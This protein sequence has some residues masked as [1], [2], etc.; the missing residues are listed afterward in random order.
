MWRYI[1]LSLLPLHVW[2]DLVLAAIPWRAP[3]SLESL[4]APLI[5]II[6]KATGQKVSFMVSENYTQL[7]NQVE[8]AKADIAIFGANSYIEAKERIPNLIYLATC[9]I[10]N[11]HYKSLLIAHKTNHLPLKSY[12]SKH[13]ALT[14]RASTSGYL[15]PLL[16]LDDANLK[17]KDFATVT[18]LGSHYRVY[19]A[20][21]NKVVDIGGV[22]MTGF[23]E[24]VKIHGDIFAI[25]QKSKPIP[26]DPIAVAPHLPKEQIQAIQ[27]ALKDETSKLIFQKYQSDLKGVAIHDDSYYDIVRRARA[28]QNQ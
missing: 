21:A 1:F 27:N 2:A 4:Y 10:P 24:A 13:L 8:D 20:I 5:E 26:Q 6:S 25:I 15:Y 19:E 12:R 22:S 3:E 18:L 7:I 9:K 16:M 23:E 14:D 28:W 17:P 11:D